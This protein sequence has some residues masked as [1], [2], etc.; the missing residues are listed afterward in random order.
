MK[1]KGSRRSFN[2]ENT[3][4]S[5]FWAQV[6]QKIQENQQVFNQTYFHNWQQP[7]MNRGGRNDNGT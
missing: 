2:S 7:M 4:L 3:G 1:P 6:Q 5:D